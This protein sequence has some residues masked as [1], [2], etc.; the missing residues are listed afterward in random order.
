M[1]HLDILHLE[2]HLRRLE[3]AQAGGRLRRRQAEREA[4]RDSCE[5]V[6]DIVATDHRKHKRLLMSLPVERE[7]RL[8]AAD[9]LDIPGAHIG[10]ILDAERQDTH[11][12]IRLRAHRRDVRVVRIEDD[13]A[14][15]GNGLDHLRL[16]LRDVLD[17][18]E[19]L[20]VRLADIRHDAD[21]RRR[22]RRHGLNLVQAAHADLDDS[23]RVL[24]AQAQE[25]QRQADL[26]VVVGLRLEDRAARREHR[27]REILR[28]RLAV[29]ARDGDDRQREAHAPGV[30]EL[31]IG[32]ERVRRD[33]HRRLEAGQLLLRAARADHDAARTLLDRIAHEILAVEALALEGEEQDS[34]RDLARIRHDIRELFMLHLVELCPRRFADLIKRKC[35]H[36]KTPSCNSATL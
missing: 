2:A 23:S 35:W 21:R 7:A 15:C 20:H 22:N 36:R 34:R 28:R 16:R 30:R 5:R 9:R 33:E 10:L 27:S 13:R 25:R 12:L 1:V 6:V 24:L 19:E 29:R 18:T 8:M 4:G 26:I 32:R 11:A 17:G 31:L 3:V 14:T